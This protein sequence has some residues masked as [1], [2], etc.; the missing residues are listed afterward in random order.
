M[1][2]NMHMSG[3]CK[4]RVDEKI[5]CVGTVFSDWNIIEF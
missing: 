1:T 4:E 2:K 5:K 3:F